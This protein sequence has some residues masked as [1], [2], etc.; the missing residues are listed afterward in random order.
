MIPNAIMRQPSWWAGYAA[1]AW[2][3]LFAAVSIYWAAGGQA[4]VGTLSAEIRDQALA[5][6]AGFVAILWTTVLLKLVAGLL[7]LALCRPWGGS[8][9]RRLILVAG[10][11]TGVLLTLYGGVGLLNAALAEIG[12]SEPTDP[13]TIRWYLFL[14]EPV[15]LVGGILFLKATVHY[16]RGRTA[17]P[18]QDAKVV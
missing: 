5:R 7:G 12:V 9:P 6:R 11:S 16:S 10:W 13:R 15:W 2:G 17:Q 3:F 18:A 8:F 14:W 4:G 1:A